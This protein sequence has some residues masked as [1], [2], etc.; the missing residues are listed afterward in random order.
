M[1]CTMTRPVVESA[2]DMKLIKNQHKLYT[3]NYK[4]IQYLIVFVNKIII[5]IKRESWGGGGGVFHHLGVCSILTQLIQI[6]PK[7]LT[8]AYTASASHWFPSSNTLFE[9]FY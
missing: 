2:M 6:K 9:F 3:R 8:F 5:C 7:S 1:T 4:T